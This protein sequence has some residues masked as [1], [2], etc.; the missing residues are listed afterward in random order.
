MEYFYYEHISFKT[1]ATPETDCWHIATTG[2][3]ID[4]DGYEMSFGTASVALSTKIT[5]DEYGLVWE[6]ALSDG[7]FYMTIT[8]DGDIVDSVTIE[9]TGQWNSTLLDADYLHYS[10]ARFWRTGN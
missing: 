2:R 10:T 6:Y 8:K 9:C 1:T 5:N 3:I 7:F 4:K